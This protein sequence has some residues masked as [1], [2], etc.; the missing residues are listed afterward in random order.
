MIDVINSNLLW[1]A[2]AWPMLLALPALHSRLPWQHYLA[3]LP[4]TLLLVLPGESTLE[5][6]RLVFGTGLVVDADRR[7]I[8]AMSLVVWLL[9]AI[10]AKRSQH[11]AE[12]TNAT[13]FFML[14]LAGNLGVVLANDL[15]S[16]FS[17]A[18]LM[19][20][21]FYALLIQQGNANAQRAGRHYL[22]FLI[23]ADL[24]LFEALLLVASST[25]TMQFET[26]QQ[27]MATA[28]VVEMYLWMTLVAFVFKS[29][30]WPAHL[31]LLAAFS[32]ASR[33]GTLLLG[34]V[35]VA[36]AWLGAV[37]WLPLGE[38][39]F[40][41]SGIIILLIGLSSVLYAALRLTTHRTATLLPAWSCIAVSGLLFMAL[42]TGL[43][44]HALW[45]RY[46]YLVYPF[47]A[48]CGTLL[49]IIG[50]T[51]SPVLETAWQADSDALRVEGTDRWSGLFMQR[52]N[53]RVATLKSIWQS[54]RL[55]TL[56]PC[57]HRVN[58]YKAGLLISGWS[59]AIT[60]FVLLGLVMA[61]LAK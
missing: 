42:G 46:E 52:F 29:G 33:P 27:M 40:Y 44:E 23:I 6:P 9:A 4:T 3:M 14:A 7:W 59:F 2:V 51:V 54:A 38:Q 35:P 48:L 47:I 34:A 19:G 11:N 37:R 49:A 41:I 25:E 55:Q 53:R 20:Y 5:L 60:L 22:L 43:I 26:V 8:L 45:Q 10:A 13:T 39:S 24:A 57:Q 30:A 12:R 31:W 28:P 32:S 50:F 56:K 36:M 61:W 17:F 21:S 16:F 1:F 58:Y 18:T 15:V